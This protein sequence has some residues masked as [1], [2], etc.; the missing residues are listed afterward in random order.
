LL[1]AASSNQADRPDYGDAEEQTWG[2]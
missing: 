2:E 1:Q